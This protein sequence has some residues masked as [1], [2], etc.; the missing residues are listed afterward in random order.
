MIMVKM[1]TLEQVV[2]VAKVPRD[3]VTR[4]WATWPPSKRTWRSVQHLEFQMANN[5]PL[6]HLNIWNQLEKEFP[7]M[8]AEEKRDYLHCRHLG[9]NPL[10]MHALHRAIKSSAEKGDGE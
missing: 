9:G 10:A 5:L 2:A 1:P 8:D 7:E 3:I 6:Y 4:A